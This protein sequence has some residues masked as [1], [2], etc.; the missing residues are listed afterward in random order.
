MTQSALS[1]TSDYY[2]AHFSTRLVRMGL[3]ASQRVW[4][5]FAARVAHGMFCTPF[6]LKWFNR[7][8]SLVGDWVVTKWSF[9]RTNLTICDM[10]NTQQP[11][12]LL[13]H[14]WGGYAAQMLPLALSLQAT[15]LNPVIVEMPAHGQSAGMRSSLPQF[16]RAIEYIAAKFLEHG[17][18]VHTV[19]AH[20]L[21]ANA[22]A[23]AVSRGAP[24]RKLVL[25]APPASPMQYTRL[26]AHAFALRE[27]TRAAMQRRIEA[28]EAIT[29]SQFEPDAVAPRINCPTLV[30]HDRSD[31]IN[32]FADGEA[33]AHAIQNAR[34]IATDGL[35]HRR[36]LADER[37]IQFVTDFVQS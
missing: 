33:Y 24:V 16:A 36:L 2:A 5:A 30:V 15:D 10:G 26:F 37:V 11:V 14:G 27:S 6:P 8:R 9:E 29:M 19:I 34:F 7:R 31:R 25:L 4:P 3:L 1:A 35:G 21:G 32:P 12:V 17:R 22:G 13:I 28:R 23:Y 18:P 20:S